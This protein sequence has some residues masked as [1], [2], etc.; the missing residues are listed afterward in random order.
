[1]NKILCRTTRPPDLLAI[2]PFFFRKITE[3]ILLSTSSFFSILIFF[4]NFPLVVVVV[5]L[6][7]KLASPAQEEDENGKWKKK[8][9]RKKPRWIG[10]ISSPS[11]NRRAHD[12]SSW[13]RL[14]YC[15]IISLLGGLFIRR[16]IRIRYL[17]NLPPSLPEMYLIASSSLERGKSAVIFFILLFFAPAGVDWRSGHLL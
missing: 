16:H 2:S 5:S 13:W 15:W 8:K 4:S 6:H 10:S 1:M 7:L 14:A 3:F 9:T 11:K 17:N 12:S